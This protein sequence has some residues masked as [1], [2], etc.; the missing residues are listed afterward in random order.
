MK[1]E[2][3]SLTAR[4]ITLIFL[5]WTA[6]ATLSSVNRL[7]DPRGFGFRMSPAG[8]ITLAFVEAWTWAAFTPLIFWLSSRSTLTREQWLRIPLLLLIGVA[9]AIAV[10]LIL[11]FS[12]GAILPV[13][14]RRRGGGS[15]FNPLREI[16]RFRFL[17]QLIVYL[18][19]LA[20]GFAREFFLRDRQRQQ[21]AVK[22]QAQL[23]EARLDALRMQI[24]PH[25]LFNTLHAVSAL[26]ERDPGGVRKMISRLAELLRH[27]IES[28][29]TDEVPLREELAF[30]KR[31]VE[32][33]EIRFQGRLEV[34][35]QIADDV[36]DALVP[37]LVLQPI[38][39]NALEHGVNRA[40]GE[41]R[42]EITA[43][44]D[45]ERLLLSVRDNG[46]GLDGENKSG[47]GLAN[48][49]ARLEQL[50]GEEAELT[51][52]AADGGGVCAT[53]ALPY[54]TRADLRLE[55]RTDA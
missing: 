7:L 42:I 40:G 36:L 30:L 3:F 6:L 38:V 37:N 24:N 39:E 45:D 35:M 10:Y 25:F 29:A 1:R 4:E 50:Y 47:V 34:G 22:L 19:V 41:G 32:I 18:A 23:A 48:T 52:T 15:A 13:S 8:P 43:T 9:I 33:M 44:R 5:F 20:T 51:L 12:R 16:G 14:P 28:H 53:I 26:V 2:P 21:D 31:Y 11:D 27:T 54:H 17:N 46:A 55:G 49:R